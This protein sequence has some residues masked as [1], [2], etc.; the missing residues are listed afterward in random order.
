MSLIELYERVK[1]EKNIKYIVYIALKQ[2]KV[3][4]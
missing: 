3:W 2:S 4:S 1:V